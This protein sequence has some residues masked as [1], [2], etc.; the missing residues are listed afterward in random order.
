MNGNTLLYSLTRCSLVLLI[1]TSNQSVIPFVGGSF[2]L[3]K[4]S[5][6]I[7]SNKSILIVH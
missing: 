2:C 3:A 6:Y 7:L 1:L 5:A 4:D